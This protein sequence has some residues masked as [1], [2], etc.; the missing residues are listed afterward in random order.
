[1]SLSKD[2]SVVLVLILRT[3]HHPNPFR[4]ENINV[5]PVANYCASANPIGSDTTG[6]ELSPVIL[7]TIEILCSPFA[8]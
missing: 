4:T 1:M 6:A 5:R 7:S 8:A 2:R 3:D